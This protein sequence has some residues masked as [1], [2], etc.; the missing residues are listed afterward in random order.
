MY[1]PATPDTVPAPPEYLAGEYDFEADLVKLRWEGPKDYGDS[2]I[3]SCIEENGIYQEVACV[4]SEQLSFADGDVLEN[5]EYFYRVFAL[6]DNG[7]SE[8]SSQVKIF[9]KCLVELPDPPEGPLHIT[10]TTSRSCSLSWRQ[11]ISGPVEGYSVWKR[12]QDSDKWNR[13]MTVE[14]DVQECTVPNLDNHYRYN[15]KI[16]SENRAGSSLVALKTASLVH[17]KTGTRKPN[18]PRGPL[19]PTVT[20]PASMYVEWGPCE[21][22]GG[23]PLRGYTIWIREIEQRIWIEVLT[24][25]NQA[26]AIMVGNVAADV[27]IFTVRDLLEGHE[28]LVRVAAFNELGVGPPLLVESPVAIIRPA[29]VVVPPSAPLGPVTVKNLSPT[30]MMVSWKAPLENGGGPIEAYI[31]EQREILEADVVKS[32][33]ETDGPD[34]FLVVDGLTT[35]HY[36][37][38]RV[39][40]VNE[41]GVGEALV[42]KVPARAKAASVRPPQPDAPTVDICSSKPRSVVVTWPSIEGDVTCYLVERSRL[43][44]EDWQLVSPPADFLDTTLVCGGLFPGI[45]YVFRVSAENEHGVGRPSRISQPITVTAGNIREPGFTR[46]LQDKT[47]LVGDLIQFDVEYYGEPDP[48][49]IWMRDGTPLESSGRFE[50][51]S[52]EGASTLRISPV[53]MEDEGGLACQASNQVG[54]ARSNATLSVHARPEILPAV[55]YT[56][57]LCFDAGDSLSIQLPYV[58]SPKPTAVW[59]LNGTPLDLSREGTTV[60]FDCGN[61][62]LEIEDVDR[63][64][65][66]VYTLKIDNQYGTA[67]VDVLVTVTGK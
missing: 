21:N 13:V 33:H 63:N 44:E 60:C 48:E 67:K 8:P 6:N 11:P 12:R 23:A 41:S 66:G 3:N 22:D 54:Q 20:G 36:Y 35:G 9:T 16:H 46:D 25:Q 27:S 1:I 59:L 29:G 2:K 7:L 42:G 57:G 5:N 61:A 56:Q 64:L 30:S 32:H 10:C 51:L 50:V 24:V 39:Y 52:V 17:L 28:Y 31:I 26:S 53:M 49:I 43:D 14:G 34:T 19:I 62:I 65:Q 40:A 47:A 38:F 58:G 18:A 15:F 37:C 4:D 55:R 45:E